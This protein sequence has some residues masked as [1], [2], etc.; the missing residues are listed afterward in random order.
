M[1]L[2]I[3]L[4]VIKGM[5]GEKRFLFGQRKQSLSMANRRWV[6]GAKPLDA[7]IAFLHATMGYPRLTG[8]LIVINGL[9]E[10]RLLL[11]QLCVSSRPAP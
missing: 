8:C 5:H 2:R 3:D 7:Y 9:V 10:P 6:T 1:Y 4:V 11:G